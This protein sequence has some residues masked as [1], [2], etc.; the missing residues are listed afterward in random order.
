MRVTSKDSST[1]SGQ[2]K[3]S[4]VSHEPLTRMEGTY[5]DLSTG[6]SVGAALGVVE[7]EEEGDE[8]RLLQLLERRV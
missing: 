2:Q 1:R 6:A 3:N 5:S 7:D 8:Q 4:R